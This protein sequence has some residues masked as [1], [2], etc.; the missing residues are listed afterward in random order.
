MPYSTR[1]RSQVHDSSNWSTANIW[2][3]IFA[4]LDNTGANLQYGRFWKYWSSY[5]I[6]EKPGLDSEVLPGD[7]VAEHLCHMT[8]TRMAN[9]VCWFRCNQWTSRNSHITSTNR[10]AQVDPT[11]RIVKSH[12]ARCFVMLNI[13]ARKNVCHRR[14]HYATAFR[15]GA[16][17]HLVCQHLKSRASKKCT[18]AK[19]VL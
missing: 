15:I 8:T 9:E 12:L 6:C 3:L 16:H 7:S 13:W 19:S 1:L 14:T 4:D 11:I 2:F 18:N 10:R 5:K 17:E